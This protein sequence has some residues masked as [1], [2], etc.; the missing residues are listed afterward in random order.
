MCF[1][2]DDNRDADDDEDGDVVV[3]DGGMSA[4]P[5]LRDGLVDVAAG[6]KPDRVVI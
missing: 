6:R 1:E 5:A 2:S 4:R 3:V